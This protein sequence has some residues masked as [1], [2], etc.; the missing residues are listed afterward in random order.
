MEIQNLHGLY[1]HNTSKKRSNT[2]IDLR[3]FE[4]PNTKDLDICTIMLTASIEVSLSSCPAENSP[5][6]GRSHNDGDAWSDL[7]MHGQS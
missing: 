6:S 1:F 3:Y 5:S 2:A 4:T 7:G